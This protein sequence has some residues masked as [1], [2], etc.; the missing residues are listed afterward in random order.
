MEV[1]AGPAETLSSEFRLQ[2]KRLY[3]ELNLVTSRLEE[4]ASSTSISSPDISEDLRATIVQEMR[5]LEAKVAYLI[6][7]EKEISFRAQELL[8]VCRVRIESHSATRSDNTIAAK[9]TSSSSSSSGRETAER[10]AL[11]KRLL[12]RCGDYLL[13]KG[14]ADC[15]SELDKEDGRIVSELCWLSDF[16]EEEPYRAALLVESALREEGGSSTGYDYDGALQLAVGWCSQHGSRLR[17][18][19]SPL[20]FSL[21]LEQF[22]ALI[23]S[24]RKAQAFTHMQE[25]MVPLVDEARGRIDADAEKRSSK[26]AATR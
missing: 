22:I 13:R 4:L 16:L 10:E 6:E 15:V 20:E 17:R 21:R 5:A 2:Q 9:Q 12:I 8:R 24:G 19:F 23:H 3:R 18:L 1:I 14:Y 25:Q 26:A 7:K 11:R